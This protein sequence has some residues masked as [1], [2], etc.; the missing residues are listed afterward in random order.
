MYFDSRSYLIFGIIVRISK[1]MLSSYKVVGGDMTMIKSEKEGS[2]M[3][4]YL[5]LMKS[6]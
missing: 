4:H 6:N 2:V 5:L 3:L 1:Q